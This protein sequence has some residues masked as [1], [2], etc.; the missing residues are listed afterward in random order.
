LFPILDLLLA[1]LAPPNRISKIVSI[2]FYDVNVSAVDD[3]FAGCD[4]STVTA[5]EPHQELNSPCSKDWWHRQF[6]SV[7]PEYLAPVFTALGTSDSLTHRIASL[8][9]IQLSST[10]S[11][12]MDAW[13]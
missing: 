3:L 9:E 10:L 8:D 2:A 13:K 1:A 12:E 6:A 11:A 5:R 7:P 4:V